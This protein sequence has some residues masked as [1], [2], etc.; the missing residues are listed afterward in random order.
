MI[1]FYFY[2]LSQL[3]WN[4]QKIDLKK[5]LTLIYSNICWAFNRVLANYENSQ[6]IEWIIIDERY[7]SFWP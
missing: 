2:F 7:K 4:E 6:K 1:V 3:F 5:S